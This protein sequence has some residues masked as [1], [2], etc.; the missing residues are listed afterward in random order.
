LRKP[1]QQRADT[2]KRL[3]EFKEKV[4]QDMEEAFKWGDDEAIKKADYDWR[5]KTSAVN[6]I[7]EENRF[8]N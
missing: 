3:D 8:F 6:D 1:F 4:K 2:E 7:R 5:I